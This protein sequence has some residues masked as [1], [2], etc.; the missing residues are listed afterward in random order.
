MVK[1]I[2]IVTN[3]KI[4]IGKFIVFPSL[5]TLHEVFSSDFKEHD[6]YFHKE[7]SGY[8]NNSN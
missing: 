2:N 3:V 5:L 7:N 8:K 4:L 1:R 6:I